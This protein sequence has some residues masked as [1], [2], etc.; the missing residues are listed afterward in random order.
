M[1]LTTPPH[2]RAYA[3]IEPTNPP[4]PMMLTFMCQS[5]AL[6][7]ARHHLVGDGFDQLIHVRFPMQMT[8]CRRRLFALA[9][10]RPRAGL[11][12]AAIDQAVAA[13]VAVLGAEPRV[14]V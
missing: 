13:Q 2:W 4:P 11:G 9:R 1:S 3:V 7:H 5:S 8:I 14:V 6:G 12:V 10:V